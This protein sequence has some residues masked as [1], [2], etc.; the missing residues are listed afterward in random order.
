MVTHDLKIAEHTQRTINLLDGM[1]DN[2]KHNGIKK[3]QHETV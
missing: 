3:V 1:V 2:V